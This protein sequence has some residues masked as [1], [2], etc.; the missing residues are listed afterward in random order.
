[1]IVILAIL[2]CVILAGCGRD[3]EQP[4]TITQSSHQEVNVNT[5]GS[6]SISVENRTETVE[7]KT[8]ST[9]TIR[10]SHSAPKGANER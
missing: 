5:D 3:T 10:R 4:A 7:G 8:T 1:M 2:V 6:T 9:T